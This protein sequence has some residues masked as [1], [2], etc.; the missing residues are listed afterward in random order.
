MYEPLVVDPKVAIELEALKLNTGVVLV[1]E[2][3]LRVVKSPVERVVEP[4]D[5]PFNA[6]TVEPRACAVEPKVIELL[7]SWLL[8]ILPKVPPK[9][10]LPLEVTVPVR[11]M[12]FTDPVPVSYTHLTLPTIY[13]V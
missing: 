13:S 9:V 5:T 12:P 4:I 3:P 2:L 10:R 7:V 11:V 6:L 1:T 8:P